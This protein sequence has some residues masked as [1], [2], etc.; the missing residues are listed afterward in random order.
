[1]SGIPQPP[2]AYLHAIVPWPIE[3]PAGPHADVPVMLRH[4]RWTGPVMALIVCSWA[5]CALFFDRVEFVMR[6]G[7]VIKSANLLIGCAT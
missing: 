7:R 5:A 6:D 3:P 1:M 2:F 4:S